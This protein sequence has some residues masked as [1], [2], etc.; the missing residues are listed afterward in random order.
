MLRANP[1]RSP[2][3]TS[4]AHAIRLIENPAFFGSTYDNPHLQCV[5]NY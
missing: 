1:A 3:R 5:A 2:K 4:N